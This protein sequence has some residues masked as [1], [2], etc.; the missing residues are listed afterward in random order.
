MAGKVNAAFSRLKNKESRENK[1]HV[2]E[3]FAC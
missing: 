1:L 3:A 2:G